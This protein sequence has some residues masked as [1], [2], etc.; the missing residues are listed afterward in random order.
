MRCRK[1]QKHPEQ[2]SD[3]ESPAV[4]AREDGVA[5]VIVAYA[6]RHDMYQRSGDESLK[7]GQA[8]DLGDVYDRRPEQPGNGGRDDQRHVH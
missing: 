6:E 8:L 7:P 1:Q 3:A 5:L 2:Q 4:V